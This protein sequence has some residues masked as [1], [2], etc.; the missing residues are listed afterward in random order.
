MVV[1]QAQEV[2]SPRIATEKDGKV[3]I[4]LTR[5]MVRAEGR[6]ACRLESRARRSHVLAC[7]AAREVPD[8]SVGSFCCSWGGG[9]VVGTGDGGMTYLG[10]LMKI[11]APHA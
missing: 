10:A 4:Y 5:S 1:L 2:S 8:Q 11:E 9:Q 3:Y 7:R 6:R